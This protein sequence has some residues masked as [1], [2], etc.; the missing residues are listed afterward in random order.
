MTS[1]ISESTAS[2]TTT[3]EAP[4]AR[5]VH[6]YLTDSDSES[7]VDSSCR[8]LSDRE[9][10]VT[11]GLWEIAQWELER[12]QPSKRRRVSQQLYKPVWVKVEPDNHVKTYSVLTQWK[13]FPEDGTSYAKWNTLVRKI[14][15]RKRNIDV[16]QVNWEEVE[17]YEFDERPDIYEHPGCR[18][19]DESGGSVSAESY[20]DL[21]SRHDR[22]YAQ[23]QAIRAR[24]A[25]LGLSIDDYLAQRDNFE[26]SDSDSSDDDSIPDEVDNDHHYVSD[27]EDPEY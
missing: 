15:L 8:L 17:D 24:A 12:D 9:A 21:L 2:S 20:L 7:S 19:V 18:F 26:E 1:I 11:R 13:P 27:L 4:P 6:V 14:E 22:E 5:R 23:G 25:E 10:Y 16:Y 3:T